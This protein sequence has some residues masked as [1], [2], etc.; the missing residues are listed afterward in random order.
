MNNAGSLHIYMFSCR[1]HL[2]LRLQSMFS[3]PS[4]YLAKQ[5]Y[6]GAHRLDEVRRAYSVISR[7]IIQKGR[8]GKR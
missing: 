1:A 4:R 5:Q 8:K 2:R 3:V 7:L 6:E